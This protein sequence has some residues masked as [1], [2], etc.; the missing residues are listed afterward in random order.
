VAGQSE[1]AARLSGRGFAIVGEYK[2]RVG[3]WYDDEFIMRRG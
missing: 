3:D 1:G 2:F